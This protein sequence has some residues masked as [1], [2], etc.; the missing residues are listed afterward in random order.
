MAKLSLVAV[1]QVWTVKIS[2]NIVNARI[3]SINKPGPYDGRTKTRLTLTN[4]TTG[5]TISRTAAA[6]RNRSLRLWAN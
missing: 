2:G 6:L 4:L 3:E 5:R 1:G